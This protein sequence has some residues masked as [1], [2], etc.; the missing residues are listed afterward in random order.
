MKDWVLEIQ[1]SYQ[2]QLSEAS[3]DYLT[4][5]LALFHKHRKAADC[6]NPQAALGNLAISVELMLKAFIASKH[7]TLLFKSLPLEARVLMTCPES[8]PVDFN[9]HP[10]DIDIRSASAQYKTIELDECISLFF[11]FFPD[12]KQSLQSH[13]RLLSI[14]RNTSIHLLLPS[15]HKYELD[16]VAY[17]ALRV[18]DTLEAAKGLRFHYVHS[19]ED[20]GFLTTFQEERVERVNR[21]IKSAKDRSKRLTGRKSHILLTEVDWESFVISCPVCGNDAFLDGDTELKYRSPDGEEI[22]EFLPSSFCC[23]ECG[24]TLDDFDE[25]QLAG[26]PTR[27]DRSD[28]MDEYVREIQADYWEDYYRDD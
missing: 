25:L 20:K 9:W 19:E 21:E 28:E 26:I 1:S 2:S 3:L 17:V 16:R 15:F 23:N 27:F 22:L 6:T 11:I 7:I 5:G 10:F 12:L 24:L 13:L 14:Y 18:Y 8:L 4:T